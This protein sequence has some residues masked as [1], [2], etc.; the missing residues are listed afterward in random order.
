[1]SDLQKLNQIN[2]ISRFSLAFVLFYQ[3]LVP[4]IL[5][6]DSTETLLVELHNLDIET[7]SISLL[8]GIIEIGLG[9]IILLFRKSITPIYL[10]IILFVVLLIDVAIIQPNLLI[11]AFNPLTMNFMGL[12]LC[13]ICILST[14]PKKFIH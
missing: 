5:W 2:T 6:L 11:K 12:T 13:V 1:M 9:L 7:A 8:G 10:S 4:K 14:R 3:G